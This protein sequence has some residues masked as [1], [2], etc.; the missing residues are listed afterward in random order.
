M[1]EAV[2]KNA[3]VWTREQHDHYVEPSWAVELLADAEP[4][5]NRIW[6]P[7]CGFGT[8]PEVFLLRGHAVVATDLIDRGYGVGGQNFLAMSPKTLL[9]TEAIVFNPPYK[10]AEQ[11]VDQAL[12][13]ST[14]KVAALLPLQW[15]GSQ[16]RADQFSSSWPLTR[17]YVLSRRPSMLPGWKLKQGEKATG[18]SKDFA[19]FVFEHGH[20]GETALRWLK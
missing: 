16:A 3:H 4:F 11:M 1:T 12:R 18:G 17:V 8:I 13:F 14:K 19:W 9:P 5:P 6:D 10:L 15:L 7:C 2:A 20:T